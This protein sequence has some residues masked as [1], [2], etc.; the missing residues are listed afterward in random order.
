LLGN[1]EHRSDL[2]SG[3][4][5]AASIADGVEQRRVDVVLLLHQVG[6]GP[7]FV[8]LPPAINVRATSSVCDLECHRVEHRCDLVV[9]GGRE[10]RLRR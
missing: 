10:L 2:R 5:K 1:A 3:T 6:D 7:N 4:I 9:L 8:R